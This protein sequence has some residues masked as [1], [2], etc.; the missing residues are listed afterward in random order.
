MR[1][2]KTVV[3]EVVNRF[4]SDSDGMISFD[5]F[6][7][8]VNELR[9]PP[10]EKRKKPVRR[11]LGELTKSLTETLSMS[12]WDEIEN[13]TKEK[14]SA[15]CG[16]QMGGILTKAHTG[17]L[18]VAFKISDIETIENMGACRNTELKKIVG[19]KFAPRTLI[20][21]LKDVDVPL[22]VMCAKPG[23]VKAW[24][25]AFIKCMSRQKDEDTR[26]DAPIK[27]SSE[28]PNSSCIDWG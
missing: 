23:C 21:Y 24:E 5:E 6:K 14:R 7:A 22:V 17:K 20:I 28:E 26:A 10:E 8:M 4:D 19:K 15:T 2:S 18:D 1:L 25:N 12:M 3:N 27:T 9:S 16:E 13:T 11:G